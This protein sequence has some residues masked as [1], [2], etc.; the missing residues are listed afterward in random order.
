MYKMCE[1]MRCVSFL[2][3]WC[4]ETQVCVCSYIGAIGVCAHAV[5][6]ALVSLCD[7]RLSAFHVFTR[8]SGASAHVL[9]DVMCDVGAQ[10]RCR[11]CGVMHTHRC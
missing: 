11:S 7:A 5:L 10:R 9:T 6:R 4:I 8:R 2:I 3:D 1:R